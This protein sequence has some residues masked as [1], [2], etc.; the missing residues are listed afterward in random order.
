MDTIIAATSDNETNIMSC[1]LAKN[2]IEDHRRAR[3]DK[4]RPSPWSAARSTSSWPS[5]MGSDIVLSKK[6]LAANE[7]LKYI[8]RGQLLS[9]AHLHGFE[10]EVVELVVG[11]GAPIT[12]KAAAPDRRAQGPDH[13]RRLLA[14]WAWQTAVGST[15]LQPGD[16]VIAVCTSDHLR[17][18]QA[19]ILG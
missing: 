11:D 4:A 1:V 14:R 5:T 10:A 19:L 7:I 16:K 8:R 9:V 17:D 15:H 18:L 13:H 2:L 12:R 6:V 3:P